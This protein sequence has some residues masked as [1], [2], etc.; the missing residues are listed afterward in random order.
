MNKQ[1][2]KTKKV[3]KD[4][5]EKNNQNNI[6]YYIKDKTIHDKTNTLKKEESEKKEINEGNYPV[7]K[8][9]ETQRTVAILK[10]KKSD[11]R[12]KYTT[13]TNETKKSA[14]NNRC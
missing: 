6:K 7:Q 12:E 4:I 9:E 1:D 8:I 10:N 11:K 3:I 13:K 14:V 2:I 5:K